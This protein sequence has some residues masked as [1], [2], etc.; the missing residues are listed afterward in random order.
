MSG[1]CCG[2]PALQSTDVPQPT[3]RIDGIG[4]FFDGQIQQSDTSSVRSLLVANGRVAAINPGRADQSE[5]PDLVID[6]HGGGIMPGL[7]DGHVHP[8]I[9]DWTP[10]VNAIGWIGDYLQGGTT[11]MV[12]AGELHFPGLDPAALTPDLATAI[13]EVTAGTTPSRHES[14]A[15]LHVGTLLLVPG[16][17]DAHLDRAAAAG[18]RIA[19]FLFFPLDSAERIAEA[20]D[21]V[22]R[23]AERGILTKLHTGGVSRSGHSVPV[24]ADL[25]LEVRPHIAAHLGGGPIPMSDRD[26]E[27]VVHESDVYVEV[28][29]SGNPRASRV[30]VDALRRSGQLERLTLG[31][32]TPGGT[33]VV[34]RGMMRNVGFL[35]GICGLDPT[36]AIACATGNTARAHGLDTGVLAVGADADLLG[37]GQVGGS[38]GDDLTGALQQG[39]LPGLSLV[40]T[41]GVLRAFPRTT[42]FPPPA[43]QVTSIAS[44]TI[45]HEF[46][47]GRA[48]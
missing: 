18:A 45:T 22:V 16:M 15:R 20:R 8:V 10:V 12:S 14:G 34:P 36:V 33:G 44:K 6:M 1:M 26:I 21:L 4:T 5:E 23:L 11:T 19:K 27:R 3:I 24:G 48:K 13:V 42:Q 37:I 47:V 28:C 17:T 39:D 2:A 9:G 7:I 43:V 32:D 41:G 35:T 30:L 25:L 38:T 31:T 29:T 46:G 40:M